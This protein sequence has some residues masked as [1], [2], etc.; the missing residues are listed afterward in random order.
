MVVKIGIN[1]LG[2]IGKCVFLQLLNDN[3]VKI[4]AINAVHLSVYEI[5]DYLNHDSS[6]KIPKIKV[7]IINENT[8]E[9]GR[10]KIQL[11]CNRDAEKL[12]WD[13]CEYVIDATG[14]FLTTEMCKLH[15]SKYVIMSAPP[16]DT[17]TDTF[18]YGANQEKYNGEKIVSGSSCTTNCMAPM[19]K[20]LLDNYQVKNCNF[21]TIHSATASQY[22]IDVNKKDAR[23]NRSVFNNIIP[24]STGASNSIVQI[25]PELEGQ[26]HGTSVRVPTSNCSLLDLN[27]ELENENVDLD[28]IEK[29][30][31]DSGLLNKLYGI[32]TKN[33]VSS[34]FMTTTTPTIFDKK[35]SLNMGNG[36]LKL[37]L[38]YDNEWSYS[39]QLI[40]LVKHMY[41]F[42]TKIKEKYNMKNLQLEGKNV[43]ARFDFNVA[44]KDGVIIDDF[45]IASAIPTIKYILSQNPNRLILTSHFGRPVNRE[46]EFSLQFMI[47][48][49]EK[50]LETKVKFLKEGLCQ[51]T[52]YKV[53]SSG[54]YLLENLR[55][56]A[57]ETLYAKQ[58]I[59]TDNDSVRVYRELGDVFIID[60]FGCLHREHMS[61]CDINCSDKEYGYGELVENELVNLNSILS[62]SN[63]KI[64]G[65]IGGAKIQ[66][67]MPFIN[68]LRNIPNTRLFIAGGLAK[69]YDEHY[70]N[71]MVMEYGVGNYKMDDEPMELSLIDVKN[72]SANFFDISD[73]SIQI[74]MDEILKSDIIF[75]NGPLGVIEH[76]I[77]K[78]GSER[79]AMFLQNLKDKKIIVGGGETASLFDKN[80]NNIYISTGGGALLEYIQNGTNMY[81]LRAFTKL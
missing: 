22:T 7:D 74:L 71:V 47:P 33:L 8:F 58:C 3:E 11:L 27:I 52:L 78:K 65:I 30:I 34:D 4:G 77:Y 36:K 6:H 29:L 24:H 56:H 54:I 70:S 9:I 51:D 49:L 68:T 5:E 79:I 18:I 46:D 16:K 31:Q 73:Q 17:I 64:L 50:Y 15:N 80:R 63:E 72:S 21:I 42:N 35:A 40:R 60:A 37:L 75:W 12:D 48:V 10:H 32:N 44:M 28:T 76:E 45:R 26:I 14:A 55:F 19:M 1:G 13:N 69:H 41:F 81:G 57:I 66:D 67:K 62:N 61:I 2:R 25:F 23:T 59:D 53:K 39:A 38:W 43:V 20:L